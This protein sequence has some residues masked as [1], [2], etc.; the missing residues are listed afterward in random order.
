MTLIGGDHIKIEHENDDH[1]NDLI[2]DGNNQDTT[3]IAGVTGRAAGAAAGATGPSSFNLR[4]EQNKILE[5]FGSNSKDTIL[6][7]DFI[8][9]LEDLAKTNRW[10]DAQ[11]YYHFANSLRNPA[12]E[13]LS[14]VVAWDDNEHDQPLCSD[15]KE[16]FT[17]CRQ[18]K[19]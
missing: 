9:R 5:F 8:Q 14:S 16:V 17:P 19:G 4:V 1:G 18:T 12:R 3:G 13:W 7:A 15:F 6:A 10:S 11:T 2:D